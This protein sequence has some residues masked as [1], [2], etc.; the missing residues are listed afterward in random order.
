LLSI[1][2]RNLFNLKGLNS[3]LALTLSGRFGLV[4]AGKVLSCRLFPWMGMSRIPRNGLGL[5]VLIGRPKL[6]RMLRL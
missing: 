3:W 5:T 6:S 1:G 4:C 2:L